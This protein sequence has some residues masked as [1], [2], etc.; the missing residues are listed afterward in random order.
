MIFLIMMIRGGGVRPSQSD[1]AAVYEA[2]GRRSRDRTGQME[3]HLV[4]VNS[5]LKIFMRVGV[6]IIIYII[7]YIYIYWAWGR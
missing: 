5:A 4:A 2:A 3:F 7:L 6:Y 1:C